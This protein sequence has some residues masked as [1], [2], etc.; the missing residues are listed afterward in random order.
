[1]Y[2]IEGL[3]LDN[4]VKMV[5]GDRQQ[6][7]R[8]QIPREY[9]ARGRCNEHNFDLRSEICRI[10][11]NSLSHAALDV[12]EDRQNIRAMRRPRREELAINYG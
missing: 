3:E 12:R 7:P 4:K 8:S 10:W 5:L 9:L 2:I 11:V 1:M 6:P